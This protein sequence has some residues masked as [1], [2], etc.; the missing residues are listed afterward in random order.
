M[1]SH[2]TPPQRRKFLYIILSGVAATFTGLTV[3]PVW[4]YLLPGEKVG[5][6]EK[7]PIAKADIPLGQAHFFSFRGQPAVV[8]Q[9]ASGQFVAFSAVCTHLGCI[10]QWQPGKGKAV[11]IV[12]KK[13]G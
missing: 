10:I 8:L 12:A 1:T 2:I 3:W 11:F 7:I 13:A 5:D 9:P 6:E 4:R